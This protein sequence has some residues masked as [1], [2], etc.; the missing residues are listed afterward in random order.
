MK[1]KD[2]ILA[3]YCLGPIKDVI[4]IVPTGNTCPTDLGG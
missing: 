4:I 2:F 3:V 1:L